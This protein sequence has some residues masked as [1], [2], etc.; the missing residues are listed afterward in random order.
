MIS[1]LP[2]FFICL[3]VISVIGFIVS[4]AINIAFCRRKK[5]LSHDESDLKIS[6]MDTE[7]KQALYNKEEEFIDLNAKLSAKSA[8]I[9]HRDDEIKELKENRQKHRAEVKGLDD[10]LATFNAQK[11]QLRNDVS[12]AEQKI[13]DQE[14]DFVILQAELEASEA[15]Y[16]KNLKEHEQGKA[17]YKEMKKNHDIAQLGFEGAEVKRKAIQARYDMR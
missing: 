2:I 6:R 1:P 7:H 8:N 17:Q 3:S 13:V 14:N 16:V 12:A 10:L 11:H 4:L 15:K 9:K 5:R